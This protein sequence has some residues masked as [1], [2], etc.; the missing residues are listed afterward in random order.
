MKIQVFILVLFI[1]SLIGCANNE[2]T[3]IEVT[4]VGQ[5][6]ATIIEMSDG[7]AKITET[8]SVENSLNLMMSLDYNVLFEQIA[9]DRAK[10][11]SNRID[12]EL[13]MCYIPNREEDMNLLTEQ[14]IDLLL[15]TNVASP[16]RISKQEAVLDVDLC[17]RMLKS[18]Y[19]AYYYLGENA[20]QEAQKM[21]LE[22]ITGMDTIPVSEL[23]QVLRNSLDFMVDGHSYVGVPYDIVLGR[24]SFYYCDLKVFLDHDGY[25]I[26]EDSGKWYIDDIRNN[27]VAIGR[28]L[29]ETG[30][31]YYSPILHCKDKNAP[32]ATKIELKN[33]KGESLTYKVEWIRGENYAKSSLQTPMYVK[34][35]IEG[36][37]YLALRS[38][39]EEGN[40]DVFEQ[41]VNDAEGLRGSK[42]IIWDLRSNG[43]GNDEAMYRWVEAFSG[44]KPVLPEVAC[45]RN[46][47]LHTD[48]SGEFGFTEPIR[49]EMG[50]IPNEIPIFVL[51]DENCCSAGESALNLLRLMHNVVV[52][53]SNTYGAQ[54]GGNAVSL[55]LPNSKIPCQIG[56]SLR[57]FYDEVNVDLKGYLPDVWCNPVD[58]LDYTLELLV[59]NEIIEQDVA[60][61]IGKE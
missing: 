3:S 16:E 38:F 49:T 6:E 42:L 41:F 36:V 58:A 53:G 21:V 5:T 10:Q 28:L 48:G 18:A 60:E 12:M 13:F 50:M 27:N 4:E 7:E 29:T 56:T 55:Y 45:D 39:A 57:F 59:Q 32:K 51:V 54:L 43:G 34:R 19:G 52:V 23:E 20:F 2:G 33:S 35:T 22:W 1:C 17:F 9:E 37:S 31:V 11:M 40:Q 25:Y 30:E 14:E 15:E 8:V 26:I 44:V 47:V 46:S 24:Y 61:Q